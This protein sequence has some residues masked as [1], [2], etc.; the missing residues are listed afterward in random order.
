[1][2]FIIVLKILRQVV[3]QRLK[4]QKIAKQRQVAIYEACNWLEKFPT[5]KAVALNG[6][7]AVNNA[8]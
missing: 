7:S 3:F 6:A 8:D 4:K 5:I 2:T 1:M